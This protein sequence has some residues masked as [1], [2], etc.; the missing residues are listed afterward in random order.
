MF[1]GRWF[2]EMQVTP[3]EEVDII[4]EGTVAD[5]GHMITSVVTGRTW[6]ITPQE[7]SGKPRCVERRP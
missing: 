4:Q 7:Y 6:G 1:K 2:S 3:D 5:K